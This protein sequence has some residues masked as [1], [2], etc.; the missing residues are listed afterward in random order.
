LHFVTRW[1][2]QPAQAITEV[3]RE[4]RTSVMASDDLGVACGVVYSD[5]RAAR[6]WL[7]GGSIAMGIGIWSMHFLGMLAFS[8]PMPMGYDP[9]ITL[10]SLL[11]AI[12]SSAF[13]LWMVCQS[14]LTWRRLVVGALLMGAGVCSMHYTG[15]A[16]MHMSPAIHYIPSLL[17]L[18]VVIA[19]VASGAALWIAF[20][21]RN[22][23]K[24]VI[25]LRAA[26]SVVM[27]FAIA[28]THYTGMAAAQFVETL[29]E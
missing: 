18:S 1:L 3:R 28:G 14:Y 29:S 12:A 23:S 16:A 25:R 7:A 11:V 24:R 13:A 21:P 15:M 5:G 8:L 6:W 10:L 4:R 26:A 22:G 19:V 9:I 2:R 20:H 17:A 27:G